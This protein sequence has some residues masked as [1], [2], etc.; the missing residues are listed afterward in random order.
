MFHIRYL[1]CGWLLAQMAA[2]HA[3][4]ALGAVETKLIGSTP[5]TSISDV[6]SIQSTASGGTPT[7]AAAVATG[8]IPA[9][10]AQPSNP[11]LKRVVRTSWTV[12]A[13]DVATGLVVPNVD[14]TLGQLRHLANS[15]GHDHDSSLRPK[16]AL[17]AYGGNT[18]PSGMDLRIEYS[19]PEVSG[20]VYSDAS[21]TG[22][23]GFACFP[24][25]YYSFTTKVPN[26]EQLMAGPAYDLV[27][28]TS[29]HSSNHWGTHSFVTKLQ[30]AATLYTLQFSGMPDPKLAIN[31]LALETG[32]LFDVRGNWAPPHREHRIGV[33]GDLRTVSPA[34][35]LALK[36]IL[37][38]AGI[39]GP[40]LI[41]VPP[42]PPHWHVREFNT[43]E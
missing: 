31:D 12:F 41:H 17:S 11:L 35:R 23:N 5:P 30:Q 27:G 24:G 32:G 28:S 42:D 13:Y 43:R 29:T 21:C 4:Y 16:G 3:Q 19:S 26:L 1:V 22:P 25:S 18:G 37:V 39:V 40:L 34:R 9:L 20:V 38:Q 36:R 8:E 10:T 14:V 7:L 6:Q 33:V 15:G 2:A